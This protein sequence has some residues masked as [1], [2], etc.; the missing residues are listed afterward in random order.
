MKLSYS[1]KVMIVSVSLL[2]L[3]LIADIVF[4]RLLMS[5]IVS[6]NDKVKQLDISS[7]ER[8]KE[9]TFRASVDSS[10][11]EREK[12]ESYFVGPSNSDTVEFT[13]YL[14]GL[15]GDMNLELKK[16]LEYEPVGGLSSSDI[17][18]SI[19]YRFNVSGRWNDVYNFIQTI[20]NLPKVSVLRAV[21]LNS[22]S[23]IVSAKDVKAGTRTWS[24]D[25][26]FSVGR[27]KN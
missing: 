19:R 26:D 5:K 18:S 3:V 22:D 13:K 11:V 27:L 9:L 17:V 12:L 21:S 25:L 6:I 7:Q 15:A 1:H 16:T 10:K 14:E 8:L 23:N 2:V 4:T 20:E 24:A